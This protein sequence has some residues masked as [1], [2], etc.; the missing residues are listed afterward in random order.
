M[1]VRKNIWKIRKKEEDLRTKGTKDE[2]GKEI[3]AE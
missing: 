2:D 1:S 3:I